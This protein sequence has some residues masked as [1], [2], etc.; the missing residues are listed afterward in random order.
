MNTKTTTETKIHLEMSVKEAEFL[1]NTISHHSVN[2][3]Y[4]KLE[5][6]NRLNGLT[7]DEVR[8]MIGDFYSSLDRHT[9]IFNQ[10]A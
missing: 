2:E 7:K 8:A 9:E 10:T 1:Y 6:H 4:G 3:L 5:S